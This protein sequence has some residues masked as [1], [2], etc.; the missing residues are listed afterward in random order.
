MEKKYFTKIYDQDD[1]DDDGD[2]DNDD[3]NNLD[4]NNTV[5]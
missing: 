3:D 1:D 4:T 5:C 2:N